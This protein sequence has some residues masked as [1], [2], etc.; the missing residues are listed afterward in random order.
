MQRTC[1]QTRP[2]FMNHSLIQHAFS[3]TR[4]RFIELCDSS[5][6]YKTRGLHTVP[7]KDIPCDVID[8]C[9]RRRR[10]VEKARGLVLPCAQHSLWIHQPPQDVPYADI[11]LFSIGVSHPN[12]VVSRQDFFPL[13]VPPL[14]PLLLFFASVADE[15][16]FF[17]RPLPSISR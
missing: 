4:R 10:K 6:I 3:R 11:F 16:L 9:R 12:P 1:F 14:P 2:I 7:V 15:S 17:F 5:G 8:K 13:F